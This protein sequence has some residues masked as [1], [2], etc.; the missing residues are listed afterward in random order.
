MAMQSDLIET[1]SPALPSAR[2][3]RGILSAAWSWLAAAHPD[4]TSAKDS[5][6][7]IDRGAVIL[8]RNLSSGRYSVAQQYLAEDSGGQMTLLSYAGQILR[9]LVAEFDLLE[10]LQSGDSATWASVIDRLE[11]L[12]YHWLGPEGREEWAAWEAREIAAATC[13]DLWIWLQTHPYPFDVPFERWAARALVNRLQESARRRAARERRVV[14]SLDQAAFRTTGS[15]TLGELLVDNLLADWL[16]RSENR[17]ALLQALDLLDERHGRVVHLW[18]LDGLSADEIAAALNVSVGNVYV[19]RFR[20]IE[21]LRKL[22]L[23]NERLGLTGALPLIEAEK[24]RSRPALD[25]QADQEG[26]PR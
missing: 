4:L 3:L 6:A 20:A 26:L 25:S 2:F 17:E 10:R 13:A 14:A 7:W 8:T 15:P 9:E 5:E 16:E 12:G 21:K 11:R 1:P 24:R 19:M 22:V 18:Y 23:E